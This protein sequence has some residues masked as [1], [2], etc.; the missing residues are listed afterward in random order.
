MK[1]LLKQLKIHVI[2]EYKEHEENITGGYSGMYSIVINDSIIITF[3]PE[4]KRYTDKW[5]LNLPESILEDDDYDAQEARIV[6]AVNSRVS[7]TPSTEQAGTKE[8][9]SLPIQFEHPALTNEKL[10][11]RTIYYV[12]PED[13]YTFRGEL[14]TVSEIASENN[15]VE[16]NELKDFEFIKFILSNVVEIET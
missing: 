6:R 12:K 8:V 9:F 11:K 7:I 16:I 1:L 2:D 14:A 5:Y 10:D 13:F 3:I 15:L 4:F